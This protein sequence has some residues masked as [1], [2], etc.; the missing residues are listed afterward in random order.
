MSTGGSLAQFALIKGT[1][2]T[3]ATLT[4]RMRIWPGRDYQGTLRMMS[5][6]SQIIVGT[7]DYALRALHTL[8]V[9]HRNW[10]SL[11]TPL[12]EAQ[13]EVAT[14][15]YYVDVSKSSAGA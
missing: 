13:F 10:Q 9:H 4:D 8:S 3:L 12:K 6:L 11:T 7:E 15:R 5:N 14:D 2:I 1:H